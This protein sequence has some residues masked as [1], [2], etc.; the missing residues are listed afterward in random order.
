MRQERSTEPSQSQVGNTPTDNIEKDKAQAPPTPKLI[1][2]PCQNQE[3]Q[4]AMDNAPAWPK[5]LYRD[6]RQQTMQYS[7]HKVQFT[8]FKAI[9][10]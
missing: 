2:V 5:V 6:V 9:I 1:E 7:Q 10:N 8:A 4:A 3:D